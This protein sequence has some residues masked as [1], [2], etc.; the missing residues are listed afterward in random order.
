MSLEDR[1]KELEGQVAGLQQSLNR[2]VNLIREIEHDL[3]SDPEMGQR[4]DL[5]QLKEKYKAQGMSSRQASNAA[6][7]ELHRL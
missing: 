6:W 2:Y 3:Y 4:R 5:R 7:K 1:V